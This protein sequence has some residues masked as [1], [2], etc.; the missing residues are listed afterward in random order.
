MPSRWTQPHRKGAPSDKGN[1]S[2]FSAHFISFQNR[3][4][5]F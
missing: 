4:I 5:N 3:K 1:Y 2:F